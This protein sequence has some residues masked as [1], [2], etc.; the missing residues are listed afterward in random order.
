MT[1]DNSDSTNDNT[2]NNNDNNTISNITHNIIQYVDDSTNMI[3]TNDSQELQTY[4]NKYFKILEYYYN[5]IKLLINSDK[6]KQ[7]ISC[8]P[9]LCSN[10]NNI[11]LSTSQY[12]IDQSS[13]IKVLG[14][15]ITAG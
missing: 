12:I 6:S 1:N 4:I 5:T 8:K 10:T 14:V 3:T 13:K 7:L 9:S 15:Y 2:Q 11:K